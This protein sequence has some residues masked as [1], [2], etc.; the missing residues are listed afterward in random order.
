MCK[1]ETAS[2]RSLK[3]QDA[4]GQT[5]HYGYNAAGQLTSITNPLN[6]TTSYQYDPRET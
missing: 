1:K 3:K 4:A 5:T 2:R 6:Q